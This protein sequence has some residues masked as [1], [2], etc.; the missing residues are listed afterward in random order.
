MSTLK[1]VMEI[2]TIFTATLSMLGHMYEY[3]YQKYTIT[4]I[5]KWSTSTASGPPPVTL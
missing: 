2:Q 5:G 3:M 4:T 1:Q